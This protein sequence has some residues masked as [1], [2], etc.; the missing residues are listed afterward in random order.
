MAQPKVTKTDTGYDVYYADVEL[1]VGV[2]T[3]Q[4]KT[5]KQAIEVAT[6]SYEQFKKSQ[7]EK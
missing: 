7:E 4:A 1:I 2:S 3:Q 6:K 5:E